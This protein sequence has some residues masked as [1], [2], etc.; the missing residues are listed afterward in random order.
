MSHLLGRTPKKRYM[1]FLG[2][3]TLHVANNITI[4]HREKHDESRKEGTL[5]DEML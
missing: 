5:M 3:H 1:G 2:G 4:L